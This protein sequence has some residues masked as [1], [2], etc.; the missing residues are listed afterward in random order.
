MTDHLA[1]FTSSIFKHCSPD[2][3]IRH[4]VFSHKQGEPAQRYDWSKL[5]DLETA[6]SVI[7]W[8]RQRPGTVYCPPVGTFLDPAASTGESNVAEA[9]ALVVELDD[10][11]E[12]MRGIA[13]AIL[14]PATLVVRSGGVTPEGEDKLHLYWRLTRP[15]RTEAERQVLKAARHALG[16]LCEADMTAVPLMHPMRWPGSWH[17]K[18]EPR[19]CEI[20][21]QTEN[22]LGLDAAYAILNEVAPTPVRPARTAP[23]DGFKTTT[24]LTGE[25][26]ARLLAKIPNEGLTW[27]QWNRLGMTVWDATHASD[28]GRQAWHEWSALDARYDAGETD[29][30]WDHY[31]NSPPV[32]L[33]AA[34]L[35]HGAGEVVPRVADPAIAFDAPAAGYGVEVLPEPP[36]VTRAR[37]GGFRPRNG[38]VMLPEQQMDHFEGCVYVT[39][40]DKVITPR[41]TRLTQSRFDSVYGGHQFVITSDGQGAPSKSAWEAFIRN[42]RFAAP[43]ADDMCFRPELDPL[44]IVDE[45]NLTLVNGYIPI[46]TPR[47]EG[48]AGPFLRHLEKLFP[49]ERDRSILLSYMAFCLQRTGF[50][51]QWW[52]VIQ[53]AKGNG[54]TLFLNVM[55]YC[56]GE[57][58]SHLP[59]TSKMTRSGINFN[60]WMRN[61]LFL[62]LDEIY[63]ANRRDFLEEFKPYVT[64]RRL[65]IEA[66]GEDE[67]TGDNRANGIMLT[68]HKDGVPIDADE[69][70]YAP[71]FTRQQTAEDCLEDG[72]TSEYFVDLWSWLRGEGHYAKHGQ[73]YGF[74]IINWY[75]RQ[76]VT[77]A[78]FDPSKLATRAPRTS[79]TEEAI[80]AGRGSIE[81]EIEDAI[82]EGRTGFAGGWVS[83]KALADLIDHSR[84]R[85]PKNKRRD[86]MRSIGY[87]WPKALNDGRPTS[88]VQPDGI[89]CVLYVKDGSPY[90]KETDPDVVTRAYT[91]A[92]LET[93]LGA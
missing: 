9:P 3:W 87:D 59:N 56:I 60:G 78:E 12:E 52:P 72:L 5:S 33:S 41:G 46:E 43:T 48:D 25:E 40:L 28:E 75:L 55:A 76:Y 29:A 71:F 50:K 49:V 65:P 81:Q 8:S 15:A 64:N 92:Q 20:I 89:R 4:Y 77:A 66:K 21:E 39:A 57:Q 69:R 91:Q 85:V 6:R 13:E 58:Y 80:K 67:F 88:I 2:G 44:E 73:D 93:K 36:L 61:K 1:T 19:L 82:A 18:G 17:T 14:G 90:A 34:S 86:L 70:R 24:A 51:A 31:F 22:E 35:Y 83:G 37:A 45:G 10:R 11:P 26:A 32:D 62:G 84:I 68:N 7:E 47:T 16:T 23:R 74:R 63:S 42:Q 38:G 27:E 79:S 54:K 30:R 53:G